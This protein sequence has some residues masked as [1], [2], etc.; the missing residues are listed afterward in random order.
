MRRSINRLPLAATLHRW[1]WS[2]GTAHWFQQPNKVPSK[3]IRSINAN[4]ISIARKRCWCGFC[5]TDQTIWFYS[6]KATLFC[7][8]QQICASPSQRRIF[9][10]PTPAIKEY[11]DRR[12]TTISMSTE[13]CKLVFPT[14][15]P[16][17]THRYWCFGSGKQLLTSWIEDFL[18]FFHPHTHH[19][20]DEKRP[21]KWK[22]IQCP[23]F[24]AVV[25][26]LFG[27]LSIYPLPRRLSLIFSRHVMHSMK[28]TNTKHRPVTSFRVWGVWRND[29]ILRRRR[30][31][32]KI[33][34]KL[35]HF[36][37]NRT[38]SAS[39][40]PLGKYHRQERVRWRRT[41]RER[42]RGVTILTCNLR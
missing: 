1:C 6:F 21:L 34:S 40:C 18:F 3:T 5:R 41:E 29:S 4:L 9:D 8:S 28:T 24:V 35:I 22:T 11:S 26:V 16:P 39:V 13:R 30:R 27:T 14:P 36:K 10:W 32:R 37:S 2:G 20:E 42:E 19:P 33:K 38:R 23:N 7:F 17:L 15:P 25:F 31:R 12:W